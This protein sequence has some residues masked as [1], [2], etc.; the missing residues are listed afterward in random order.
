MLQHD[1]ATVNGLDNTGIDIAA[2]ELDV[3]VGV[4][5]LKLPICV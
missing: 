4:C 1:G 3:F 5:I 2:F